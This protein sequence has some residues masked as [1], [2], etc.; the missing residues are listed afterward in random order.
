MHFISYYL[1]RTI[2]EAK[3]FETGSTY[4]KGLKS[5]PGSG[6]DPGFSKR[7]FGQTSA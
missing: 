4:G 3:R 2:R 7:G 6:A 1:N 5:G